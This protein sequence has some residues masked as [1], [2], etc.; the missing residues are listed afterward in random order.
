[1]PCAAAMAV[2]YCSK[3]DI[4]A[5]KWRWM[6]CAM[7]MVSSN[8]KR[9]SFPASARMAPAAPIPR[10]SPPASPRVRRCA[11]R[12]RRGRNTSR[13]RSRRASGGAAANRAW[14]RST[15][16]N[17]RSKLLFLT[18]LAGVAGA[19]PPPLA[20]Q[21]MQQ[22][23]RAL[24]TQFSQPDAVGYEALNR[25]A[26]TGL[27]QQN[28]QTIQL[29]TVPA[30]PAPAAPVKTESLTPRIACLRPGALG[31]DDVSALRDAL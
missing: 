29:V 27:L 20:Q 22:I 10:Q 23:L 8:V 11:R 25:A 4:C 17:M 7:T 12:W 14:M 2:P 1:M 6:C 30:S 21:E 28:P 15:I 13:V 26:I 9:R 3:A 18:A 5:A 19:D 31:K 24:Q 16:F